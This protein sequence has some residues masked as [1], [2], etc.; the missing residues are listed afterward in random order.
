MIRYTFSCLYNYGQAR[1]FI[2]L[3]YEIY[4]RYQGTSP[5]EK[6][7]ALREVLLLLNFFLHIT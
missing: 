3:L 6:E 1:N 7:I 5:G 4:K 2:V